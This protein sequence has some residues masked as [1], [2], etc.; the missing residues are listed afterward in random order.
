MR[1]EVCSYF[2]EIAHSLNVTNVRTSCLFSCRMFGHVGEE[3]YFT[4]MTNND[5]RYHAY[6]CYVLYVHGYLGQY[7]HKVIP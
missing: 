3:L 4:N 7:N 6:R 1:R 2:E 5:Y